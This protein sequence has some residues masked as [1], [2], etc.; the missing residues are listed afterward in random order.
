MLPMYLCPKTSPLSIAHAAASALSNQIP[1]DADLPSGLSLLLSHA[2]SSIRK[3]LDAISFSS[4][5][6]L[7]VLSSSLGFLLVLIRIQL[8]AFSCGS[9]LAVRGRLTPE[10]V[11][12]WPATM[13]AHDG[14]DVGSW[15]I[16]VR[17][18]WISSRSSVFWFFRSSC[19]ILTSARLAL[20]VSMELLELRL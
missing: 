10:L 19:P 14:I 2:M 1:S 8:D 7:M 17:K 11:F 16:W 18:V 4:V 5:I 9:V 20:R 12:V 13:D 6:L 15:F 3:P